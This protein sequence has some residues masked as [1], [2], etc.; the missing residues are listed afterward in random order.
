MTKKDVLLHYDA[1]TKSEKDALTGAAREHLAT[2]K[3][4]VDRRSLDY[5]RRNEMQRSPLAA[6]YL[7]AY[8]IAIMRQAQKQAAEQ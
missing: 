8:K 4:F 2:K 7:E 6:R 3:I 5:W 1:A